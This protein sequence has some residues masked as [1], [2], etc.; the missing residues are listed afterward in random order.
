[1]KKIFTILSISLMLLGCAAVLTGCN[2]KAEENHMTDKKV[3]VAYFSATVTT[4]KVAQKLQK[5]QVQTFLKLFPNSPTV[6][7][8]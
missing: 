5:L 2:T 4:E 7:M 1:M 8:I 6:P 3:L